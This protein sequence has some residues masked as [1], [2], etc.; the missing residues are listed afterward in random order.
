MTQPIRNIVVSGSRWLV[1]GLCTALAVSLT[2]ATALAQS[3]GGS[4]ELAHVP[5]NASVV[6]YASV[7]EA[8]LSDVWA[9][10][11]PLVADGLEQ[12]QLEEQ[13]GLNIERDIDH[14]L[15]FLAPGPIAGRPSGMVLLRGQ[16]D[17]TRLE[18]VARSAGATVSDYAGTRV[19]SI[20]AGEVGALAMAALEPGLVAVGDLA[21]VHRSLDQLAVGS[22]VTADAEMMA[23]LDR[24]ERDS[25]AWAVGRFADLSA[26]G[27]LP[28]DV[29]NQMPAVTAF[30]LSGRIDSD[31]SGSVSIEGRDEEAGQHLRDLARGV[32]A[33]AQSQ[34]AGRAEL[35][36]LIDSVQL[37][38]TGTTAT[39]SF[40]LPAEALDLIF[41]AEAP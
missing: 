2:P 16:F 27:I 15:A 13:L 14:V 39:P 22:D 21:T 34:T 40:S 4:V 10:I 26:L 35:Q 20:E 11:R 19:V 12:N 38:G 29:S 17:M 5:S 7:R 36:T 28:A 18:A 32:L 1:V 31:V 30:A 33:L 41:S 23:L 8:M 24:V 6:A 9:R 25:H 37:S 3:L